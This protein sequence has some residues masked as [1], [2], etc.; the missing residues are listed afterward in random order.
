MPCMRAPIAEG[1]DVE[2]ARLAQQL[3]LVQAF[4]QG[5]RS[6]SDECQVG[7]P[8]LTCSQ[9]RH[10][11]AQALHLLAD[12]YAIAGSPATHVTDRLEPRDRAVEALLV[13]LVGL[14][15]LGRQAGELE[16]LLIDLLAAT[17]QLGGDR[18]AGSRRNSPDPGL[19]TRIVRTSVWSVNKMALLIFKSTKTRSAQSVLTTL[20]RSRPPG[21]AQTPSSKTI[22]APH[23]SAR[24]AFSR[25][26]PRAAE[27]DARRHW[28]IDRRWPRRCPQALRGPWPGSSRCCRGGD[29]PAPHPIHASAAGARWC[30]AM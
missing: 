26:S 24:R 8:D 9:S 13:V 27:P 1:E 4:A 15:E 12:A 11:L 18:L 16:L 6:P 20:A 7:K 17:D 10:A 3:G 28:A 22:F 29:L 21:L 5:S 30:S 25:A 2:L 23:I 14:G 19:H